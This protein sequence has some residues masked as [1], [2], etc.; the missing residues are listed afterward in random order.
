MTQTVAADL[1]RI[2]RFEGMTDSGEYG[3]A[4]CPHCGADG[5]YVWNFVCEDGTRR[6]AMAGCIT[7]FPVSK[8]AE[9]HKKIMERDEDRA[10]KGQK[11][12]SWDVAKLAAIESYY[13]GETPIEL[14]L[15]T[16][17]SENARRTRWMDSKK[18]GRRR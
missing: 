15:A 10:K 16:I 3:A 7:K 18:G 5:R 6:G 17:Q 1:P 13:A 11:L 2:V 9:E 14:A 4:T 12:A 8:V